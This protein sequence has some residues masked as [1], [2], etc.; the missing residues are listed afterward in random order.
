M[1]KHSLWSGLVTWRQGF[2]T[3]FVFLGFFFWKILMWDKMVQNDV[4]RRDVLYVAGVVGLPMP[5]VGVRKYKLWEG[6][7]RAIFKGP[8]KKR[9]KKI[10]HRNLEKKVFASK[11]G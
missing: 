10:F 2:S 11:K 8:R 6:H 7:F 1:Q 4:T 9:L 5:Q 3:R